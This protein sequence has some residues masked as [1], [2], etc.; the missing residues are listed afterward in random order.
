MTELH[1]RVE[2]IDSNNPAQFVIRQLAIA[3]LVPINGCGVNHAGRYGRGVNRPS[4]QFDRALKK[5]LI[6]DAMGLTPDPA[7]PELGDCMT[8]FVYVAYPCVNLINTVVT[9]REPPKIALQLLLVQGRLFRESVGNV[10]KVVGHRLV[11][12]D[13]ED[14]V[15]AVLEKTLA[16]FGGLFV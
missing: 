7:L 10:V 6:N 8:L 2:E 5:R 1:E 11:L 9:I 3:I 4:R 12:R 14:F 16:S 15:M 13:G